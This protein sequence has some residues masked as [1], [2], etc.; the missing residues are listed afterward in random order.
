M[1]FQGLEF[2]SAATEGYIITLIFL[3]SF[4]LKS[5]VR[6]HAGFLDPSR[7]SALI[8]FSLPD[9]RPSLSTSWVVC[10]G[11]GGEDA[12]SARSVLETLVAHSRLRLHPFQ[13]KL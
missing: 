1:M 3:C 4:C 8:P 13:P 5:L 12:G 11:G 10:V 7:P 9:S 2:Q 6:L